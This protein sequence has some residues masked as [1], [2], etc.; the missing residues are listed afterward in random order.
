MFV[1][2]QG[3]WE[4]IRTAGS[5]VNITSIQGIAAHHPGTSYQAS[6]SGLI[7]LTKSLAIELAEHKIRVNAIAPGAIATEGMGRIRA[8]EVGVLDAYRRRIPLGRRGDPMEIARP[9]AFLC[10]DDA[11]YITGQVLVVDGGYISMLTPESLRPA[12]SINP[13]DPDAQD[14]VTLTSLL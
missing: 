11:S 13:G 8:G 9:A 4:P 6:K 5:I 7:G 10:S 1:P 14:I 2:R 12:P 3:L